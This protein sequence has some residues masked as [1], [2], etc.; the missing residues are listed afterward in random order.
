MNQSQLKEFKSSLRTFAVMYQD[1]SAAFQLTSVSLVAILLLNASHDATACV[2]YKGHDEA[3]AEVKTIRR[4]L[5]SMADY[6][7]GNTIISYA[8]KEF[9]ML[10]DAALW[11][12][13]EDCQ[14]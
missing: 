7:T 8:V 4:A 5:K 3:V 10:Y 13:P 12:I 2:N 11:D 14:L 6:E 9:E 1:I